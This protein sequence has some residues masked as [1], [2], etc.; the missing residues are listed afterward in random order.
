MDREIIPI[1]LGAVSFQ[2][3]WA[4]GNYGV[5]VLPWLMLGTNVKLRIQNQYGNM[6]VSHIPGLDLGIYLNPLDH[7]RFGDLGI[8]LSVQDLLPTQVKW[9]CQMI[10][11]TINR[12]RL[13]SGTPHSMTTWSSVEVLLITLGQL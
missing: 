12:S 6:S 3:L 9:I 2:D 13:E 11:I 7:Y 10:Q 5:R 1:D 8:N 4:I